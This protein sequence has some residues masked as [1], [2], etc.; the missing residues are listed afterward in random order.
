MPPAFWV[1]AAVTSVSAYV[2]L[3]YSVAGLRAAAGEARVG[4]MYALARS[5]ALAVAATVA[6]FSGSVGFLVAVAVAMVV[7]Q[8]A[9][10]VVGTR[11]HD[12]ITTWGPA[13][14]AVANAAALGWLGASAVA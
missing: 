9:D 1:C 5:V 11:L 10:A 7:V 12:R 14:T 4:F 13:V 6:F 8:G 2:S 3:G